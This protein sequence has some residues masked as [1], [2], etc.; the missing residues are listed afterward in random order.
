MQITYGQNDWISIGDGQ[1]T[2]AN[3]LIVQ[4]EGSS[5]P[6]DLIFHAGSS[7]AERTIKARI[8]F[9]MLY[10]EG[11]A[12]FGIRIFHNGTTDG[13]SLILHDPGSLVFHED[14]MGCQSGIE[15]LPTIGVYYWFKAYY[16]PVNNTCYGKV[17][18]DG[19]SEPD[20]QV[21]FQ[22]TFDGGSAANYPY[23]GI[24][25]DPGWSD[26]IAQADNFSMDEPA[27]FKPWFKSGEI[28]LG[29]GF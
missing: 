17:W 7:S 26:I 9:S 18:E 28:M 16:N 23:F 14:V 8:C 5:D 19:D 13:V 25:G 15:W 20:W 27:N 3:G 11:E 12:R 21:I 10:Y 2:W 29:G 22:P 1:W 6:Q 4:S 24:A